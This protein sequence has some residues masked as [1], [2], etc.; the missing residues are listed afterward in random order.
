M[1]LNGSKWYTKLIELSDICYLPHTIYS[2]LRRWVY[3]I[4]TMILYDPFQKEWK[5]MTNSI[6]NMVYT[7][8]NY[9]ILYI[10][11]LSIFFPLKK[12]LR[13]MAA[14]MRCSCSLMKSFREFS[15]RATVEGRPDSGEMA[16]AYQHISTHQT[17]DNSG[18]IKKYMVYTVY[19]VF[20][21]SRDSPKL[22]VVPV[23]WRPMK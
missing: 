16:V 12:V 7:I 2:N 19:R 9:T 22:V 3:Q 14:K 17:V 18:I 11:N 15:R 23:R 13:P 10:Y 8:Y 1:D 4:P 21:D 6:S 20:V 5:W